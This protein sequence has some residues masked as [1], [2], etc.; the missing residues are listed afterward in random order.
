M[1][2]QAS[3]PCGCRA[4]RPQWSEPEEATIH[5]RVVGWQCRYMAPMNGV[6]L[7]V[8]KFATREAAQAFYDR[9]MALDAV[10]RE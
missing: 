8:R 6:P 4:P 5:N 1:T 10:T 9:E 7:S 3:K 2:D